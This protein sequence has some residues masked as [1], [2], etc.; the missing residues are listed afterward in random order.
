[1]MIKA[2]VASALSILLVTTL[3]VGCGVTPTR[4]GEGVRSAI[5]RTED[6]RSAS[7]QKIIYKPADQ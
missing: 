3:L 7:D 5:D 6:R 2:N 1:M 4:I